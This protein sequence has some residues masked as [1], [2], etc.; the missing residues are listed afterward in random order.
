M[1]GVGLGEESVSTDV[2]GESSAHSVLSPPVIIG[3]GVASVVA[4]AVIIALCVCCI[5]T[6]KGKQRGNTQAELT[7]ELMT[8]DSTHDSSDDTNE[9]SLNQPAPQDSQL[10]FLDT[11]EQEANSYTKYDN[12]RPYLE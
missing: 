4:V 3:V 5:V 6:K 9:D 12:Q 1:E 7:R 2:L 10:R 8:Y 11:Q